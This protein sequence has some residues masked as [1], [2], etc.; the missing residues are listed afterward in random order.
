MRAGGAGAITACNNV[1]AAM[2]ASI[3]AGWQ[4]Q[5]ADALQETLEATRAV[6]QDFPLA[7]ALKEIMARATGRGDWR[8]IRPP[9]EPLAPNQAIDLFERLDSLG[10]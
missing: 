6:I 3:Y 2:S 5:G 7:A 1:C 4:D 9:Q 10:C 8:L